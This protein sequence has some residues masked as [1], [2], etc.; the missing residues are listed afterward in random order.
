MAVVTTLKLDDLVAPGVASREAQGTHGRFSSRTHHANFF[1]GRYERTDF[2]CDPGFQHA[3]RA[4]TESQF[5]RFGHGLDYCRMAVAQNHGPPRADVV[6]EMPTILA[7]EVGAFS[8]FE[9]D[10]FT[11]Y[12]S[13]CTYW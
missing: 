3:R 9:K 8:A 2:F 12:G 10:G 11:T 6:D 13:K 4:K 5:C 1:D 7:F